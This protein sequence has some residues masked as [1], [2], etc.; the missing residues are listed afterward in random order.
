MNVSTPSAR[1]GYARVSSVDQNLS[2]QMSRLEELKLDEIFQD[3]VSGKNIDRPAFQAMM[4]YVRKGD[5]LYVC[6]MDRLARNLK[7]LLMVTEQLQER[8][9]T[10][11]FLK[12][13]LSLHALGEESPIAKLLLA[14]MGAVAEFERSLILE[15]Q[16]EGIVEAK[17][18]HKY[19][20][21]APIAPEVIEKARQMREQGISMVRISKELKVGRTSLYKY[22]KAP[23]E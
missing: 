17:K 18:A 11:H 9:V 19:R 14:M 8:G 6:S 22:M 12:E 5:V 1:V 15:R 4:K 20:G 3:T 7:D 16:R 13:N 21:R 2:R 10:I 23:K